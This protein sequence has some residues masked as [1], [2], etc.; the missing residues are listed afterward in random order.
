MTAAYELP[1]FPDGWYG[2]AFSDEIAPGALIT[3]RL[4]GEDVILFRGRSGVLAAS[5][6]FCPHMGAHFGF[7]GTVEGETLRCPFHGFC[8]DRQGTCVKT[9]Y[10]TTPP[11]A[12]L[13][14]WHVREAHGIVLVWHSSEGV[15]P[16]WFVPELDTGGWSPLLRRDWT[17]RSHPQETT[18]NSVDIGHLAV[19]HGYENVEMLSELRTEGPYLTARYAMSR[20][21]GVFGRADLLR[22]EFEVHVW[23]LGYSFVDVH[24]PDYGLHTRHFVL[25]TPVDAGQGCLRVA[26]SMSSLDDPGRINPALRLMPK[27]MVNEIVRRA[28]FH[29]F[30]HDVG[31]DFD[32]WEN[33]RYVHPPLLAR[34]DGP[35]VQYRAWARQFYPEFRDDAQA[36]E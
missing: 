17:L 13:P 31:Q 35:V 24:V 3:R 5:S 26:L 28:T 29:G 10:G 12:R 18:E 32:V 11:R 34:G 4:A 8:F 7:G 36:A 2:L 1:P 27:S 20:S 6:A 14:M 30:C 15:A 33:K 16:T 19:V 23:G 21:A 22:A 9:G 25:S